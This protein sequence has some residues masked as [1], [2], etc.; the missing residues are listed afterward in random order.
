MAKISYKM[1]IDNCEHDDLEQLHDILAMMSETIDKNQ[2][3]IESL[4]R[5]IKRINDAVPS[6][7]EAQ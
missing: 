5:K 1:M 6:T 2:S 4:K 3:E 7:S